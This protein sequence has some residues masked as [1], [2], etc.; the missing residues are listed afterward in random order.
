MTYKQA[1]ERL[2]YL[3]NGFQHL[4]G[5]RAEAINIVVK[6]TEVFADVTLHDYNSD[7]HQRFNACRYSRDELDKM[8]G[9]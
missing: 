4:S 9:L 3:V 6:K 2:E 7:T 5:C 8:R 1:V